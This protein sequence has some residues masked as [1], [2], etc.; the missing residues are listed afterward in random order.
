MAK[1]VLRYLRGTSEIGLIYDANKNT[2]PIAF[3]DADFASDENDSKSITGSVIMMAGAAVVY[4]AKKQSLV[5]QSTTEVEFIAAAET[6]KSIIWIRELLQEMRYFVRSPTKLKIDNKVPYKWQNKHQ[7]T[8]GP[9]T[10]A[11]DSMY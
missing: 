2:A 10:F 1:R 5:G 3:S 8:P 6:S 11:Y 9:N 4:A 7:L